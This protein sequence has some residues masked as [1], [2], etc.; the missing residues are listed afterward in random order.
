MISY[1]CPSCGKSHTARNQNAGRRGFCGCGAVLV[2][3]DP[4]QKQVPPKVVGRLDFNADKRRDWYIA[5]G[6]TLVGITIVSALVYTLFFRDA[7]ENSNRDQILLIKAHADSLVRAKEYEKASTRY[8][9]LFSLIG[10]RVVRD[11]QL[12]AEIDAAHVALAVNDKKVQ[13]IIAAR[14]EAERKAAEAK[15]QAS[16]PSGFVWTGDGAADQ[17]RLDFVRE[18]QSGRVRNYDD[19]ER[20]VREH[21]TPEENQKM[22]AELRRQ[23]DRFDRA[24][25]DPDNPGAWIWPKE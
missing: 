10:N 20:S 25:P 9:E 3:P 5:I 8:N 12:R 7:W 1:T 6:G 23:E 11:N 14:A 4:D 13:P 17:R 16:T 2:V 18:L 22:D 19:L 15:R 21:S 24:I